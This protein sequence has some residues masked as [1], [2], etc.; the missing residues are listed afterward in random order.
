MSLYHVTY[1]KDLSSIQSGGLVPGGR[2][3]VFGGGYAGHSRGRVFLAHRDAVDFWHTRYAELAEYHT[4]HPEEGWVPIVLEVDATG[5][6]LHDDKA[7]TEDS[8]EPS[9]FTEESIESERIT[10]IWNGS[11]WIALDFAAEGDMLAQALAAAEVEEEDGEQL[12]YMD[13]DVF[14]PSD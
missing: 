13:F 10:A 8:R 14:L 4:D 9:Y 12:Y 7:G 2:G 3:Q 11:E 5:L 1:L 6:E